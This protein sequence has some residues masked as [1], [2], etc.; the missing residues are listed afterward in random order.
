VLGKILESLYQKVFINIIRQRSDTVVYVH[1][2]SKKGDLSHYEEVFQ[3]TT[4]SQEMIEYIN[5]FT[6]ESPYYYITV[7]DTSAQQGALPSCKKNLLQSY[8]DLTTSEY[9]CINKEWTVYTSKTDLYTLEKEFGDVGIDFVFSP[10]IL[11]ATFFADKINNTL[12]MYALIIDSSVSVM[13]F[14]SGRLLFAEH[15]AM[16]VLDEHENIILEEAQEDVA[17]DLDDDIDLETIDVDDNIDDLEG[18]SYIENLDT[19]EDIDEF[20]QGEDLEE[21]L[22]ENEAQEKGTEEETN[23]NSHFNEDYQRFSMIQDAIN[24]F[25]KDERYESNFLENIYIADYT[26]VSNDLKRYLEDEM[27]L[28]V[29]IRSIDIGSELYSLAKKELGL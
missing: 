9:K 24:H 19:I 20:S 21:E 2:Y 25:Y 18:F 28:N 29:Y 5:S 7:L 11:L 13:V 14:D 15:V 17:L 22:Y 8:E 4:P 6:K 23:D 27:F 12:A 10:F 16:L 26:H 1:N 3:T